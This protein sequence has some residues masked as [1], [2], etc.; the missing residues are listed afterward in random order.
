MIIENFR[1][2]RVSVCANDFATVI[3]VESQL[4]LPGL[5]DTWPLYGPLFRHWTGRWP[6][7]TGDPYTQL[8]YIA[9]FT[10]PI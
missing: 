5:S 2:K 10:G 4:T 8:N 1:K 9:I 3:K 6:R 7:L